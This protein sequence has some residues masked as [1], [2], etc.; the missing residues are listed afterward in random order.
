[1]SIVLFSRQRVEAPEGYEDWS[2]WDQ[3]SWW[4][5]MSTLTDCEADLRDSWG[6]DRDDTA[7]AA[8]MARFAR[9]EIELI[10][11]RNG[12]IAHATT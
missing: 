2:D 1:M 5:W 10:E 12:R 11:F 6:A 3:K 4:S 8:A 9:E 7:A